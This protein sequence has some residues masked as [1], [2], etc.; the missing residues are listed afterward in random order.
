M[1]AFRTLKQF[2]F[3]A[4]L[5]LLLLEENDTELQ[6]S[7]FSIK[8]IQ[9]QESDIKKKKRRKQLKKKPAK[10]VPPEKDDFQV[11]IFMGCN[12]II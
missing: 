3:Q 8:K 6:K 9:D 10:E 5:E 1:T 2:I 4:E 11:L 12:H 7:H